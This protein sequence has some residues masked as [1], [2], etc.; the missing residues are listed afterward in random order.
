MN[1]WL[2]EVQFHSRVQ[3]ELR[4]L[5][6]EDVSGGTLLDLMQPLD[7]I[8]QSPDICLLAIVHAALIIL[9]LLD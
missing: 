3:K 4:P 6:E 9:L 5:V 8:G 1:G 2:K 7:V